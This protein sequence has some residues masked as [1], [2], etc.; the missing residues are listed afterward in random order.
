MWS[1]KCTY[2]TQAGP[3]Y[4]E[5][6]DETSDVVIT[7]FF[8]IFFLFFQS[9]Q[10]AGNL[11]SST[12]L[13]RSAPPPRTDEEL[14]LCGSEFCPNSLS[15][16]SSLLNR[17]GNTE[18]YTMSSIY[19]GMAL[20]SSIIIASLVDPITRFVS[21]PSKKKEASGFQLLIATF[22]HMKK[23]YQLL[24]IPLTIFSGVEQ[25]YIGADFTAAYVSC[26]LGVHMVGYV[27]ICFGACDALCSIAFTPAVKKFGRVPVFT[28]AAL[29]NLASIV[30]MFLW[31]PHPDTTFVFFLIPAL[32]GIADAV[33]QT[34]INALYGVVFPGASEAGFSNYRL[35]ESLG[36]IINYATH[37]ELCNT[38]KLYIVVGFLV[39]GM[40]G[41]YVVEALEWRKGSTPILTKDHKLKSSTKR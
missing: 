16:N 37:G 13:S 36:F 17:P 33:W 5:L 29:L 23:P 26:G 41:Y 35:W 8:G 31:S 22:R 9:S 10:V 27:M 40:V 12:V 6:T 30:V 4:A 3:V 25:G 19:L 32:W 2:L 7:R 20:L 34:Q 1:A 18:I 15:D 21:E 11:I 14:A 28:L 39:A 38:S 24:L